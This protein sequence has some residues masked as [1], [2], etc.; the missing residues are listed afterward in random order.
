MK[1]LLPFVCVVLFVAFTTADSVEDSADGTE[2]SLEKRQTCPTLTLP[3][4]N[5]LALCA[6]IRQAI[7][8]GKPTLLHRITNLSA[9]KKNKR[10]SQCGGVAA[11]GACTRYPFAMTREG[12]TGA[13]TTR[14]PQGEN[15]FLRTAVFTF[16]ETNSIGNGGCF[17]VVLGTWPIE[18]EIGKV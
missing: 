6:N 8:D 18:R 9:I 11:D 14:V 12:G 2:L 4:P 10:L 3:C 16:Y 13:A 1:V 17:N 15:G 5:M 7:N